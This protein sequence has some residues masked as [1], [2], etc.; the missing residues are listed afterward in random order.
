MKNLLSNFIHNTGKRLFP[1]V[2]FYDL[3]GLNNFVHNANASICPFGRPQSIG[4]RTS[5]NP[6]CIADLWK[7][8]GIKDLC[9][10]FIAIACVPYFV[11]AKST[12][13][14]QCRWDHSS[15]FH[16]RESS[17]WAPAPAALSTDRARTPLLRRIWPHRST[18]DL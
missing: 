5:S 3:N 17:P 14:I 6:S 4:C 8:D 9:S 10:N 18:S 12:S 13:E 2:H 11:W 1:C 7:H 16:G 15:R